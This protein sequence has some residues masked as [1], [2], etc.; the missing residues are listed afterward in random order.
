MAGLLLSDVAFCTGGAR[1]RI[2]K[3]EK[4]NLIHMKR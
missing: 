3:R 2:K 4:P 1:V